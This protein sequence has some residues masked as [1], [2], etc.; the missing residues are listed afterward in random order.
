MTAGGGA[1]KV[2]CLVM[3]LDSPSFLLCL[4]LVLCPFVVLLAS[5]S[6][7][8]FQPSVVFGA[9]VSVV[10]AELRALFAFSSL[11]VDL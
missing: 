11:V 3:G 7:P 4:F 5:P 10:Q 9:I 1:Y 6:E 8:S 2:V